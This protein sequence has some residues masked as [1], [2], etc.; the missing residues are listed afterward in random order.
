MKR[1]ILLHGF[2]GQGVQFDARILQASDEVMRAGEFAE[3]HF[4]S[5]DEVE[6]KWCGFK[7]IATLLERGIQRQQIMA[8]RTASN[9]IEE[10]RSTLDQAPDADEYIL[11]TS[12]YHLPRAKAVMRMMLRGRHQTA[13][14]T[15]VATSAG[16]RAR[17][18][19]REALSW[20]YLI[21]QVATLG[22]DKRRPAHAG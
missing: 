1:V 20:G 3:L 12:A 11:V 5:T 17:D 16:I 7:V 15:G 19:F 4:Y 10:V 2:S 9:T 8:F 22:I 14:V 13:V 6:G 18:Y 21:F